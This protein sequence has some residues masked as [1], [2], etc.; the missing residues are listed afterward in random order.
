MTDKDRLLEAFQLVK[1][2]V[3]YVDVVV[4]NAGILDDSPESFVKEIN[5]NLVSTYKH[6]QLQYNNALA[7]DSARL[8][9]MFFTHSMGTIGFYGIKSSLRVKSIYICSKFQHNWFISC[10]VKELLK[11]THKNKLLSV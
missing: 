5:I 10:S 11:N 2:E 6:L 3:G 8:K 4:N 9:K 7:R 1:D